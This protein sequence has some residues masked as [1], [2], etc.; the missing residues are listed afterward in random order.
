MGQKKDHILEYVNFLTQQRI[1]DYMYPCKNDCQ[2]QVAY[3]Y[4]TN[5]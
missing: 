2:T 1:W 5:T 4:T 3:T